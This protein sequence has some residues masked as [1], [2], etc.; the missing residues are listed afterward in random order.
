MTRYYLAESAVLKLLESP[1]VYDISRD[2]L[3][4][5]DKQAFDFLARCS[6]PEGCHSGADDAYFLKYCLS[7]GLLTETQSQKK[8]A[9]PFQSP[10]PSL[11]YLELQITDKCNLSCGHCYCG[12][13]GH[14]ELTPDHIKEILDEFSLMQGLRLLITG[15]EPLMH[16]R[17]DEVNSLLRDYPFRKILFTNGILLEKHI[18]KSLHADEIQISIDGMKN[19]HEA[20]RGA[21]TYRKVL[22]AAE[23]A[24]SAGIPVSVSTMVHSKNLDEFDAM[25]A[26]FLDLGIK[27]WSVDIPSSEGNLAINSE[28]YVAPHIGG[29]YLEYGYGSGLHGST[30]GFGCGFHLAAVTAKGDICKC[31]FYSGSPA[32]KIDEGLAVSWS[33]IQP[34]RLAD[35]ACSAIGCRFLEECRG[36]CRY[37]AAILNKKDMDGVRGHTTYGTGCDYYKCFYYGIME[38]IGHEARTDTKKP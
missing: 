12:A 22:K 10:I 37:R 23:A 29:S 34:V 20:I 30:E 16:S 11:R 32:G 14:T 25:K 9:E 4:E 13:P 36:G 31:A 6:E 8:R 19:G 5:L 15:G 33:G 38:Q 21:G 2:E 27:D 26:L 7:E 24:L 18:G 17:F 28:L 3:Y 35:L 1:C